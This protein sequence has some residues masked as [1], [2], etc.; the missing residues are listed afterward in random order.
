[1]PV[2]FI[3]FGPLHFTLRG[4]SEFAGLH[5]FMGVMGRQMVQ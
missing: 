2:L 3:P 5:R 1:V 4:Y